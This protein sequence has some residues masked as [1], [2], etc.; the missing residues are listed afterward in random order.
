MTETIEAQEEYKATDLDRINNFINGVI[1]L[2]VLFFVLIA[3]IIA[4]IFYPLLWDRQSPKGY[5]E[6]LA[7]IGT[8][9]S[10]LGTVGLVFIA[11][12][13]RGDWKLEQQYGHILA[14]RKDFLATIAQL[15]GHTQATAQNIKFYTQFQGSRHEYKHTHGPIE[16][17]LSNIH[18]LENRLITAFTVFMAIQ[19]LSQKERIRLT[20]IYNKILFFYDSFKIRYS[21][22]KKQPY[23]FTESNNKYYYPELTNLS[24]DLSALFEQTNSI[25]IDQLGTKKPT[26]YK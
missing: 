2:R 18:T 16:D 21:R 14:A 11:W 10:G 12:I 13:A 22:D 1:S 24:H 20:S 9:L 15:D 4:V 26:P 17:G 3:V 19:P 23:Q 25:K 6:I 5:F 8:W 7:N